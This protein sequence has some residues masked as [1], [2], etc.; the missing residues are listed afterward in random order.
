MFVSCECSCC[1]VDVS[2][3]GRSLVQRSPTD[4]C[5]CLIMIKRNHKNP[6]HLLWTSR[7][8][9]EGLR[10]KGYLFPFS[11]TVHSER[12]NST[13]YSI[14][15]CEISTLRRVG[16]VLRN[17][18]RRQICFIT[19]PSCRPFELS[20]LCLSVAYMHSCHSLQNVFADFN[21]GACYTAQ[22]IFKFSPHKQ[23][24][25]HSRCFEHITV[26]SNIL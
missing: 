16:F 7:Q 20:C 17:A 18:Y 9:R 5:V 13:S 1:R 10:K 24:Q 2:A 11:Q 25:F 6:R 26:P 19:T 15:N 14:C 22:Y 21:H 12:E 8:K 4:C 3:M 23:Q